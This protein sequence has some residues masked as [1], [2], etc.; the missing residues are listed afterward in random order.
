[1]SLEENNLEKVH[2]THGFQEQKIRGEHSVFFSIFHCS[3]NRF[4]LCVQH[5]YS[6]KNK[7]FGREQNGKNAP[8]VWFP[9]TKNMRRTLGK[10]HQT[11]GF[12]E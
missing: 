8:N 3:C 2:Q 5:R 7:T 11:Y 6:K 9:G 10:M 4:G 1:M 12:Q